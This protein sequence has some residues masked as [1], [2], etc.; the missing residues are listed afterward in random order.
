AKT[1]NLKEMIDLFQLRFL[2]LKAAIEQAGDR[3][4]SVAATVTAAIAV[5]ARDRN[6][7]GAAS[8]IA[9]QIRRAR[10]GGAARHREALSET[11]V[12]LAHNDAM[13]RALSNAN[14][15]TH[16]VRMIDLEMPGRP[17]ALR[18]TVRE[19]LSALERGDAA[20]TV[21]FLKRC[22]AAQIE[23]MPALVK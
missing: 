10:P 23:V 11:I 9:E 12:G 18:W 20:G 1:L 21:A 14:Q 16:Y 15:R 13:V 8:S 3:L 5:G 17:E 4:G 19:K 7:A 2:V 22:L 6:E